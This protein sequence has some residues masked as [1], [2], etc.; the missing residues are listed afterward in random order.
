MI[1][2]IGADAMVFGVRSI[3]LAFELRRLG[4]A[5][6]GEGRG[7]HSDWFER[8]RKALERLV[9]SHEPL[10]AAYQ[11]RDHNPYQECM[12]CLPRTLS[13]QYTL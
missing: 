1:W 4:R 6:R 3:I 10:H 11:P 13:A 5:G 7:P 9:G 12:M 8:S 2:L